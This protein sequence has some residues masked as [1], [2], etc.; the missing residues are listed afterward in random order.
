MKQTESALP[1]EIKVLYNHIYEYKK[2]IRILILYT[3]NRQY[4]EQAL[5]RLESRKIDY[6]VQQAGRNNINLYFGHPECLE[7]IKLFADRPLNRLTP[8]ED[9]ILGT[10]LGYDICGQ[11]RRFCSRKKERRAV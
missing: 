1:A 11:C 4:A 3:L 5:R 9:F 2:G 6:V 10:L 7:I 8:E